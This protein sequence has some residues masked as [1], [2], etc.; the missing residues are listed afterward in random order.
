MI[1]LLDSDAVA[2]LITPERESHKYIMN[3][4]SVLHKSD[5]FC[6][7]ILTIYEFEYSIYSYTDEYKKEEAIKSLETLKNSFDIVNLGEKDATTYGKLKTGYKRHTGVQRKALRKHNMD[8]AL[9]SLSIAKG[10][11]LISGDSIYKI[12]QEVEPDFKYEN[13]LKE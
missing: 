9:A 10:F 3:H 11:T 6:L 7:S 1:Y 2:A 4:I 13:W 12:L 5:S 8:I